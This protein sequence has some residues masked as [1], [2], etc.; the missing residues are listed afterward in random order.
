MSAMDIGR[1]CIKIQGREA[2]KRCVIVDVIDRNFVLVIGPEI[3]RRRCNMEHLRPL[4]EKIDIQRNAT[5]E[6]VIGAL[7]SL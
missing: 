2:G 4:D 5:D 6:E 1:V 7:K 3:R